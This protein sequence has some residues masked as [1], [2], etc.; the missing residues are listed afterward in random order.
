MEQVA[1]PV[2]LSTKIHW[3]NLCLR[4]VSDGSK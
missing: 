3:D 4:T 2:W 1:L